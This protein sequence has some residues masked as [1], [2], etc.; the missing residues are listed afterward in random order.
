VR[1]KLAFAD[2][3]ETTELGMWLDAVYASY[4]EA[5]HEVLTQLNKQMVIKGAMI[6]PDEA[7]KTWGIAPEHVAMAGNLGRG[8]GLEAGNTAAMAPHARAR[9]PGF[10][11]VPQKRPGP[12]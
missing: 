7:R 3:G 10:A 2:I 8:P 1:G 5:P 11:P 4:A 9:T 6:D 12:R